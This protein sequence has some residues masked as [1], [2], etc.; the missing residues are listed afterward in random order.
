[1]SCAKKRVTC[2]IVDGKGNPYI[3]HNDCRKPQEKCP[4][5]PGEGYEKCKSICD[6]EDHAEIMALKAAGSAANGAVAH[7]Y[8][9]THYCDACQK[10]LFSA[11]VIALM[12]PIESPYDR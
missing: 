3:G 9:I 4:R 1:M 11:G 7:L 6:Q 8:G 10:A 5:E 2:I 12:C